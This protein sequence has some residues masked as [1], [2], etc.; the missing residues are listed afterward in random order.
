MDIVSFIHSI[1]VYCVRIDV[2]ISIPRQRDKALPGFCICYFQFSSKKTSTLTYSEY[3]VC[4]P[5]RV[6]AV[7]HC[8]SKCHGTGSSGARN[9]LWQWW[10]LLERKEVRGIYIL[11]PARCNQLI[12]VIWKSSTS[13]DRRDE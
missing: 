4:G 1:L 5:R 2:I 7:L 3:R 6:V 9:F 8:V 13:Y 10:N 12:I 11:E